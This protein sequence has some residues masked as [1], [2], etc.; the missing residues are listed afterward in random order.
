MNMDP[1]HPPHIVFMATSRSG[2]GHVRRVA[3]IARALHT[4]PVHAKLALL[5]NAP[6]AGLTGDDLA[7]FDIIQVMERT[8]MARTARS[9]GAQI[10]VADTMVPEGV[11]M[12]PA[13]R[14]LILRETPGDRLNRLRLPG[15]RPW[16]LVL[17]PNPST[18]WLPAFNAGF[19]LRTSATGWIYRRPL[20]EGPPARLKPVV[21][22]AT[23]GGGTAD[24]A[25]SLARQ[26][27]EVIA[28]ARRLGGPVF[29]VVQALGP[30]APEGAGIS[31]ADRVID[32]G[33]D[34]NEHFI[35]A[36]AVISTAGYNSILELAI[37]TT[38]ALLMAISRTYDDQAQRAEAWGAR[39]GKTHRQGDVQSAAVWLATILQHRHRRPAVD[40]GPNGAPNAARA[41]LE[42]LS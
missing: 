34:L 38:P 15:K 23:G 12:V 1:D 16:D 21:L 22:V 3:S 31:S 13:R 29:D 25:N 30:R 8:E 18:H 14:G 32:P 2:L 19:A 33:G 9:W 26:A 20:T 39:L 7:A 10:I 40:I 4:E 36:D 42:L 28:A 6:V 24:T 37:T 35:S 11:E 41:I 17:I 5:T 27:E